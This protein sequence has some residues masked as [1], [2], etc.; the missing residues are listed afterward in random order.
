MKA[1]ALIKWRDEFSL[2]IAAVDHE[3]RELVSLVNEVLIAM[4]QELDSDKVLDALGEV[5][6]KISAH[7]ALEELHM[8]RESYHEY[9]IHK[10]DHERL[11]DEI[12]ELMDAYEDGEYLENREVFI[13]EITEWFVSHFSSMDAKLHDIRTKN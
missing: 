3:H 8:R 7:F 12:R 1:R 13:S 11:L 6:A 5:Y 9:M 4:D 2:G 10:E